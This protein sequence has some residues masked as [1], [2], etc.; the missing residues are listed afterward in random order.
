MNCL[1]RRLS[2][3]NI[4]SYIRNYN[5]ISISQY[6]V[7]CIATVYNAIQTG[8]GNKCK[9]ICKF[10]VCECVCKCVCVCVC[11]CVY[12]CVCVHAHVCACVCVN[13]QRP[14]TLACTFHG[15]LLC[16]CSCNAH[17]AVLNSHSC[18]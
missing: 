5:C 4:N 7:H 3:H 14:K 15:A 2:S 12:V 1:D 16:C 18:I 10:T 8:I 13:T 6:T 17:V 11:V 9:Y